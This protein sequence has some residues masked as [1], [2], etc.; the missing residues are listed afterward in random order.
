M[1]VYVHM[2][3]INI[4]FFSFLCQIVNYCAVYVNVK[5]ISKMQRS[6]TE[7]LNVSKVQWIS[8]FRSHFCYLSVFHSVVR[9]EMT[10]F[11]EILS[12]LPLKQTERRNHS[13]CAP[14]YR[15]RKDCLLWVVI[16]C[17]RGQQVC[18]YVH[19]HIHRLLW[20]VIK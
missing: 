18:V 7:Y 17:H 2:Q 9:Y 13:F 1:K 15:K 12:L 19:A 10:S 16:K 5:H 6:H 11:R 20:V 14:G 3:R 4:H 8:N